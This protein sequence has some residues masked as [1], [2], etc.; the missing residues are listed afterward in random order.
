MM[1]GKVNPVIPEAVAMICA[2][3]VG[4]DSA[5][6]MAA[7]SSE[8]QLNMMQPLVAWNLLSSIGLLSAAVR[9]LADKAIA[10][11]IV[12]E[13]RITEALRKNPIIATALAPRI[14]YDRCAEIVRESLATGASIEEVAARRSGLSA[15]E[16]RELLDPA[17]MTHPGFPTP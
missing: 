4:N 9:S 16:V 3:V 11:F 8:F 10:G 1:P 2:Q 15:D 6:T 14:G 13:K 17:R 5:I 12:N 7:S